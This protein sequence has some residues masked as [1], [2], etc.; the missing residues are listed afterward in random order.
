M[1]GCGQQHN[2]ILLERSENAV[3]PN[4]F[5]V[6][7][8]VEQGARG[9]LCETLYTRHLAGIR[10][11]GSKLQSAGTVTLGNGVP[12]DANQARTSALINSVSSLVR[13][14]A[15]ATCRILQRMDCSKRGVTVDNAQSVRL[16]TSF[17]A[18]MSGV[19]TLGSAVMVL[20]GLSPV[21]KP[22]GVLYASIRR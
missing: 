15:K 21:A 2:A 3:C 6:Q 12:A 11:S 16:I 18:N 22:V 4:L 17:E 7:P 14:M 1:D 9:S 5:P 8:R 10:C 13:V 20:L 19:F